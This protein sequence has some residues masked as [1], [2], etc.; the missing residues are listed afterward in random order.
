MYQPFTEEQLMIRDQVREFTRK[1]ITPVAHKY[2]E[3]NQH[4][5][6]LINRMRKELGINGLTIPEEYGGMGFGSV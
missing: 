1:E 4:P 5:T 6:E 2:D 3:L